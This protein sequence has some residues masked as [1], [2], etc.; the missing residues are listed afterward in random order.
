MKNKTPAVPA[1]VLAG[2][3]P[4]SR[5]SFLRTSLIA[6]SALTTGCATLLGRRDAPGAVLFKSLNDEEVETVTRMTRIMLPT[7]RHEG[8]PSSIDVVPTVENIDAM[9]AQMSANNRELLGLG[10][11][12]IERRPL[13]SRRIKRFSQMNDKDAHDYLERLQQA[14]FFERGL[15]TALKS[16]VAVN[17]WRDSRT[18]PALDYHG[19][20]TETWGVRRLGNAPLPRV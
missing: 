12:I 15:V 10:L 1:S 19:P 7:D 13:A 3:E 2:L 4:L 8:L 14:T 5:R 9:V 17:Y 20:V 6:G 11:W 16:L 18:W